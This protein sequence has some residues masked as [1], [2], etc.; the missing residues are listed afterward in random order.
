VLRVQEAVKKAKSYLPDLFFESSGQVADVRLEEVEISDD[1]KSWAVTFSYLLADDMRPIQIRQYK[2]IR[3]R[4][5]DGDFLGV[6][7]GMLATA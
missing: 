7:N 1:E 3:I 5:S 6:R 4:T 2:T